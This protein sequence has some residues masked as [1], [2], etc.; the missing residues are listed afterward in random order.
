M[1]ITS[2][3][4]N[5][6][7]VHGGTEAKFEESYRSVAN[8]LTLPGRHEPNVNVLALVRDWL[9]KADAPPWLIILDNAD[10]METLFPKSQNKDN[11]QEPLAS[12]LP[13][14]GNGKVIITSRNRSVAEKL[15]GS[16]KAIQE[17]PTMDNVE[18]LKILENKLSQDIDQ[19]A[20]IDLARALDFIPLA[21]NQAAAYINRRAPRVS[22]RSYLDE[23]RQN[24]KQKKSLLNRD[25]G[26]LRRREDVSNSVVITWQVTFEQIRQ[27]R[28]TAANLLLL[29]SFF[30]PQNIPEFMLSSYNV[31]TSDCGD[32]NG[33]DDEHLEDDLDVLRGYSLIRLSTTSGLCDMHAL[34]QFCTKIWL[35]ESNES[36]FARL[37]FLFL[38]LSAKH[39][40]IG[41]FETWARCQLLLP[42]MKP[43][44]DEEPTDELGIVDWSELSAN[45]SLY[46]LEIG[47]LF[48]GENIA[49]TALKSTK[50]LL[51]G[52]DP[53]T[54][55]LMLILSTIYYSRGR[56]DKSELL[57]VEMTETCQRTWGDEHLMTLS[58]MSNLLQ[59]YQVQ[60]KFKDAELLGLR[61]MKISKRIW[62]D[63]HPKTLSCMSSLAVLYR[64]HERFG[65][66]ELLEERVMKTSNRILGDAH[67]ETLRSLFRLAQ[68]Y[69]GQERLAEA[70]LLVMHGIEVGK[71]W[72]GG[73][74]PNVHEAMNVLAHLFK[75]RGQLKE[76]ESLLLQVLDSSERVL[77]DGHLNVLDTMFSLVVIFREQGRLDDA[78]VM[79]RDTVSRMQRTLGPD[80]PFTL[81]SLKAL[82]RLEQ[83]Q[84]Q[85]THTGE[86]EDVTV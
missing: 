43:L 81:K 59:V 4:T 22:I 30:Q 68:I 52:E 19:D 33:D 36:D 14:T 54:I 21:V 76:A 58:C 16:H 40:P 15:T 78:L 56:V 31:V 34:V 17:V 61:V 6:F 77:G 55:M 11:Q 79:L 39:F 69:M 26:D 45:V 67:P 1:H 63:E 64:I 32:G 2:P 84:A 48:A 50:R 74:H 8:A 80:A 85:G 18:A 12:Y 24:E 62:G 7:W 28:P 10:E 29:M 35:L 3:E 38:S 13:K 73:E 65:D 71:G 70:E 66:A 49:R 51:G 82:R 23:F 44:L 47:D 27:E 60:G 25:A 57:F 42:H 72:L 20:A 9:Q 41:D 75:K 83:E 37:R 86:F 46:M 5:I 53:K